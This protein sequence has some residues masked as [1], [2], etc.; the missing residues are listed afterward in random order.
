MRSSD[1]PKRA[2]LVPNADTR[3]H[4]N[5]GHATGT[6]TGMFAGETEQD[7][8]NEDATR[9]VLEQVLPGEPGS[10]KESGAVPDHDEA[11]SH[12]S[13]APSARPS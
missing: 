13:Q 3:D 11:S 9:K 10:W 1:L 12:A 6:P 2:D 7:R 5:A 8:R 4:V